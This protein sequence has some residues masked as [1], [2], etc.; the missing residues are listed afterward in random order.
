MFD[1]WRACKRRP[2]CP[3]L[4]H[5]PQLCDRTAGHRRHRN[6]S[7]QSAPRGASSPS[8]RGWRH[9]ARELPSWPRCSPLTRTETPSVGSPRWPR[10]RGH[11]FAGK[12][13]RTSCSLLVSRTASAAQPGRSWETS[14]TGDPVRRGPARDGRGRAPDHPCGRH[15][16]ALPSRL[17]KILGRESTTSAR[18][19]SGAAPG[20]RA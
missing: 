16:R 12:A 4:L 18:T 19:R 8:P 2:V 5:Q 6:P 17:R 7:R 9:P 20:K 10:P 3:L 14:W 11:S 15:H 1:G 13:S